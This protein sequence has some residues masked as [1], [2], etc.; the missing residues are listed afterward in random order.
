M[1]A[2]KSLENYGFE[3][4]LINPDVSGR[5]STELIES[6]VRD[7][8]LL[9]SVMHVNNETGIIQPVKEIGDF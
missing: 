7:D 8:T 5:V 3:V 2:A 4:E 6:R 1:E 9:V